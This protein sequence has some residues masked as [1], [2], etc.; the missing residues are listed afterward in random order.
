MDFG[1]L[2]QYLPFHPLLRQTNAVCPL[3]SE[4]ESLRVQPVDLRVPELSIVQTEAELCARC[5]ALGFTMLLT[6]EKSRA[7]YAVTR[8]QPAPSITL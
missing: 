6:L 8:Q 1:S 7:C 4:S 5:K 3:S 2:G